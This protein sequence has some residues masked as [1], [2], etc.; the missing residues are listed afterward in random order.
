MK[1]ISAKSLSVDFGKGNILENL[2]FKISS[3][4]SRIT[5]S[6]GGGKSILLRVLSG[7]IAPTNGELFFDD[8]DVSKFTFEE[9]GNLRKKIGYSFDFGGLLSNRSL[10]DNLMLPLQYHRFLSEPEA[11]EKVEG[12]LGKFD[13]FSDRFSRPSEVTGSQRKA[14]CVARSMVL[15]PEVLILDDPSTG[16][17]PSVKKTLFEEIELAQKERA[18]KFI[19]YSS[20]DSEVVSRFRGV[21]I[22]CRSSQFE[23]RVA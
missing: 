6:R 23:E 15:D 13:L 2:E 8:L 21:E 1:S 4:F 7:V 17:S 5:S 11:F 19:I 18:L 10:F 14:A 3:G 16:L 20:D 22:D 9:W 12:L